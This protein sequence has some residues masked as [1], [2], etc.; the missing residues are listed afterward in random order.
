MIS[1][2]IMLCSNKTKN[3]IVEFFIF[4]LHEQF[5]TDFYIFSFITDSK[6]EQRVTRINNTI[7]VYCG[8]MKTCKASSLALFVNDGNSSRMIP[9]INVC[10][11]NDEESGTTVSA[12]AKIPASRFSRNQTISC[13]PLMTDPELAANLTSTTGIPVCE[14]GGMYR[15]YHII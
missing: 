1:L 12:D 4:C 13:V 7:H 2:F 11:N 10:S 8:M 5:L 14:G 9:N 6:L 3:I 15:I